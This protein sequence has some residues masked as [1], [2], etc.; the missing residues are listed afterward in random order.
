MFDE[1]RVVGPLPSG[2]FK[3]RLEY[4]HHV[5]SSTTNEDDTIASFTKDLEVLESLHLVDSIGVEQ[6]LRAIDGS[7]G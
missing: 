4:F 1:I 7:I 2:L 5:P 3:L 6:L